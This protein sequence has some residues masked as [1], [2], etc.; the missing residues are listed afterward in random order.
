MLPLCIL[1][2]LIPTVFSDAIT[3]QL[4]RVLHAES[5]MYNADKV[6]ATSWLECKEAFMADSEYMK[7]DFDLYRPMERRCALYKDMTQ[8]TGFTNGDENRNQYRKIDSGFP[9]FNPVEK[10]QTSDRVCC[11]SSVYDWVGLVE[12][13]IF[14]LDSS[15]SKNSY[16]SCRDWCEARG[17]SNQMSMQPQE[18]LCSGFSLKDGMCYLY[19]TSPDNTV[20]LQSSDEN[21]Y[22]RIH[23]CQA[24]SAGSEGKTCSPPTDASPQSYSTNQGSSLAVI[25]EQLSDKGLMENCT[26]QPMYDAAASNPIPC[27]AAC[28]KTEGCAAI[29]YSID[30]KPWSYNGGIRCCHYGH[31]IWSGYESHFEESYR[32]GYPGA[33]KPGS[34]YSAIERLQ[35]LLEKKKGRTTH[36]RAQRQKIKQLEAKLNKQLARK[37][38]QEARNN[39]RTRPF[40]AEEKETNPIWNHVVYK[41]RSR[42]ASKLDKQIAQGEYSTFDSFSGWYDILRVRCDSNGWSPEQCADFPS[43]VAGLQGMK[44][45]PPTDGSPATT[46]TECVNECGRLAQCDAADWDENSSQCELFKP[47]SAYFVTAKEGSKRFVKMR[48]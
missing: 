24:L 42:D 43:G 32:N 45:P 5:Y 15:S 8:Y 17:H 28:V 21:S 10:L 12:K 20:H 23:D 47:G 27:L 6:N 7:F 11:V 25:S 14:R 30:D 29:S 4:W 33:E 38:R 36:T 31:A 40:N 13:G 39:N 19:K 9:T 46:E 37:E 26:R 2:T 3:V 16:E 48:S 18:I 35:T 1:L 44:L 34:A 22:Y 41:I